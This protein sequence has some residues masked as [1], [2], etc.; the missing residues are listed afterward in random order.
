MVFL[1]GVF[2]Y[3]THPAAR[4]NAPEV[5]RQPQEPTAMHQP[6]GEFGATQKNLAKTQESQRAESVDVFGVR[7]FLRF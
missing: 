4:S 1:P 2:S 5:K 7:G 3:E 6:S